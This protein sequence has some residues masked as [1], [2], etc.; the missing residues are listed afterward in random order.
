[1]LEL[2]FNLSNDPLFYI[3]TLTLLINLSGITAWVFLYRYHE[4]SVVQH[5]KWLNGKLAVHTKRRQNGLVFGRFT[6]WISK[7]IRRKEGPQDDT[8][9]HA[10]LF[11]FAE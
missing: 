3:V 8:D 7:M 11:V 4:T 2:A 5:S 6:R 10:F 1:M 9:D